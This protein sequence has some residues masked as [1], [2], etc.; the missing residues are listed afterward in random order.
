[1]KRIIT[2]A[3]LVFGLAAGTYAQGLTYPLIDWRF[4]NGG[5][6]P[7]TQAVY[8]TE[9]TISIKVESGSRLNLGPDEIE[10]VLTSQVSWKKEITAFS[11]CSGRGATIWTHD[12][13]RGPVSMRL[14]RSNCTNGD[15]VILRKEKFLQ[16]MVDMYNFDAN[17]FWSL[18]AGK[19][20]T[21]NWTQDFVWGP[22]FPPDCSFPCVPVTTSPD[23]G[24]L[25][26]K[27][28]KADIAVFRENANTGAT[29]F[30]INSSTGLSVQK[31]LGSFGDQPVPFDYDGDG[32]TD[33]AVWRR[34]T[35]QWFIINSLTGQMRVV[36]WGTFGDMPAPGDYDGDGKADLAVFRPGTTGTF[37]IKGYLTGVESVRTA[38][39]TTD[40]QVAADYDGDGKTD[41]AV[42]TYA[43]SLWSI[44]TLPPWTIQWG[45]SND[46]HL[47]GDYDG[48]SKA[49]PAIWRDGTWW[50]KKS[51]T[52]ADYTANWGTWGDKP[53]PQD[54]DGDGKFDLAIYR[55]WS[56]E[57]WILRSSDGQY[58]NP[59][60]G[61]E[62]DTPVPSK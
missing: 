16:G 33:M 4:V 37:F 1:M 36:Q 41:P 3:C 17:R 52:N 45:T 58:M 26:D 53:V 27:D 47:P 31:Q 61:A 12:S 10:F 55:P 62:T 46:Y 42:W 13:T 20:I 43:T 19:I 8:L 60:F 48:D 49:D 54:Y 38:G 51:A 39:T 22:G 59:V 9:D 56:S 15:T 44:Y 6:L 29:W 21:V 14:H 2:A 7:Q 5:N 40:L 28:G 11:S 30:A 18:W 23:A 24:I 50:I 32:R 34:N 25:Y 35:G 57:W